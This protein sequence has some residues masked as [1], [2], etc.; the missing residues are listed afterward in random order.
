MENEYSAHAQKLDLARVGFRLLLTKKAG[1]RNYRLQSV[2]KT[3][4]EKLKY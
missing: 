2:Y 1:S 3:M 4:C